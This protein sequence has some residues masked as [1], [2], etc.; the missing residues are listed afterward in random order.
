MPRST[1]EE[2]TILKRTITKFVSCDFCGKEAM[3]CSYNNQPFTYVKWEEKQDLYDK[4]V[5]FLCNF[6]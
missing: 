1:E 3:K 5:M 6:C 4:N 2:T